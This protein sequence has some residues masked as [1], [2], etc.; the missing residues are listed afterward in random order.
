M[1]IASELYSLSECTCGER[2]SRACKGI[3]AGRQAGSPET[4][5]LPQFCGASISLGPAR[6]EARARGRQRPRARWCRASA[7]GG[8]ARRRAA[9]FA[10]SRARPNTAPR[11]TRLGPSR[12]T[13]RRLTPRRCALWRRPWWCSAPPVYAISQGALVGNDHRR[14][15][16]DADVAAIEECLL[17]GVCRWLS[18]RLGGCV[19]ACAQ[20]RSET[21]DASPDD[22]LRP[23]AKA[24]S[25]VVR[26]FAQPRCVHLLATCM[27]CTCMGTL[28][29]PACSSTPGR[30][31][32]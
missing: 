11:R 26:D 29:A 9:G 21:D 19:R 17:E 20:E 27:G 2:L 30:R 6:V 16:G 25:D 12:P 22:S 8:A 14:A 4:S 18:R 13:N 15:S 24:L 31:R 5:R 23:R 7:P 3:Y 32:C 10:T 1:D 28:P